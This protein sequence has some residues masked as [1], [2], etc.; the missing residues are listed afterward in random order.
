[1]AFAHLY[2]PQS[3]YHKS[4]AGYLCS[5]KEI[6]SSLSKSEPLHQFRLSR[7]LCKTLADLQLITTQHRLI[8]WL[9]GYAPE[10]SLYQLSIQLAGYILEVILVHPET[11]HNARRTYSTWSQL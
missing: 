7:R 8:N 5:L 1:M 6:S 3:R 10:V 2:V 4:F 9:A 11:S